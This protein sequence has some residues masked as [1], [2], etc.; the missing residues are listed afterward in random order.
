[1]HDTVG[2]DDAPTT[3]AERE[4]ARHLLALLRADQDAAWQA[5]QRMSDAVS[6]GAVRAELLQMA[7]AAHR[8]H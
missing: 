6:D 3:D 7:V 1:M 2:A 8:L 4:L 5:L